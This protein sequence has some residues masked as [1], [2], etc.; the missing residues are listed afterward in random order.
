MRLNYDCIRDILLY[1]EANTTSTKRNISIKILL[2]SLNQKYDE[3]TIIYHIYQIESAGLV[4]NVLYAGNRPIVISDLSPEVH[5]YV[6][7]I[8]DNK[9]WKAIKGKLGEVSSASLPLLIE[10]APEIIKKMIF[11]S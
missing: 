1:I 2:E 10:M 8:R 9:V 4:Y 11:K 7:N 5:E 3:D 6:N